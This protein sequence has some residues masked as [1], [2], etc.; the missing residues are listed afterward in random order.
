LAEAL[1]AEQVDL[2]PRRQAEQPD[3]E[4]M[5]VAMRRYRDFLDRVLAL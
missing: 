2:D 3:T 4:S 1:L 5:R